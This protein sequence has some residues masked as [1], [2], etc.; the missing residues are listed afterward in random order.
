MRY[1][2]LDFDADPC[3]Y[4]MDDGMICGRPIRGV[5]LAITTP[6][7][8]AEGVDLRIGVFT[9]CRDHQS[10]LKEEMNK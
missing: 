2:Y 4:K 10:N 9:A 5:L 8:Q 7:L 1:E 3:S 6:T